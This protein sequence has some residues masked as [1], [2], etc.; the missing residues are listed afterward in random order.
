MA[1]LADAALFIPTR[2]VVCRT[3]RCRFE[4]STVS[5]S[6]TP[7]VPHVSSDSAHTRPSTGSPT[8]APARYCNTGHPRPPAPT[9]ATFAALTFNCPALSAFI[10]E[11]FT[12]RP[13]RCPCD[14]NNEAAGSPGSPQ[15]GMIICRPYRLYSSRVS[16][17]CSDAE[18]DGMLQI[19]VAI[20]TSLSE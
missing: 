8:P 12:V 2:S 9:T 5:W 13:L 7:I 19:N 18:L 1:I 10:D 4:I 15:S 6:T 11:N 16:G 17:R 3:C 14:G 20:R